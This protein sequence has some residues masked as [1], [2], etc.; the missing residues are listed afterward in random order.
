M[1]STASALTRI[2]WRA[3]RYSHK[4]KKRAFPA[5]ASSEANVGSSKFGKMVAR[6][7]Q[8]GADAVDRTFA[9]NGLRSVAVGSAGNARFAGQ[10]CR[11]RGMVVQIG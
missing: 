2:P 11:R 6:R 10:A 3:G 4:A 5:S 7:L 8:N 9:E 1:T